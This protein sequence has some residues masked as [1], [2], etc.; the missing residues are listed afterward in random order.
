MSKEQFIS[1]NK[2]EN[3][4]LDRLVLYQFL[5]IPIL[6]TFDLTDVATDFHVWISSIILINK[7]YQAKTN[8][9]NITNQIR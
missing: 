8:K 7:T 5:P 6:R 3:N 4:P 2:A 1:L 9:P